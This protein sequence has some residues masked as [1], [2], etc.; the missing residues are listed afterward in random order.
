MRWFLLLLMCCSVIPVGYVYAQTTDSFTVSQV[1]GEDTEPPTV[2]D[3]LQVVPVAAT[4]IDVTWGTS[5]DNFRLSA[6]QLF[7]DGVQIATTTQ[8]SYN[9]IGLTPSTTYA[10]FVR[11]LDWAGN[12]SSSTA[13]VATT[14]FGL[15]SAPDVPGQST[16]VPPQLVSIDID[17]GSENAR[18]TFLARQPLIYE[19]RYGRTSAVEDGFTQSQIFQRRHITYITDLEPRTQYFYELYGTDRFGRKVLIDKGVFTTLDRFV[20]TAVPNAQ[21]FTASVS[22]QNV[23]LSWQ[24]PVMQSFAYV[25]LVRSHYGYPASP[26][27]GIVVYEG[28]GTEFFD[29]AALATHNRQYYTL[30]TFD[31][32]G[33]QSSGAIALA[34]RPGTIVPDPAFDGFEPI[35]TTTPTT[36]T[37]S[38]GVP[39]AA[40]RFLQFSDFEIIQD[41]ILV[42]PVVDLFTVVGETPF[43]LRVPVDRIGRDV[44]TITVIIRYP[45]PSERTTS[46]LLRRN[47]AGTYFEAYLDGMSEE[48]LYSLTIKTFDADLR[49]LSVLRGKLSVVNKVSAGVVPEEDVVYVALSYV[50]IGGVI[51]LLTVLG[52]WWLLLGLLRRVQRRAS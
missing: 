34:V 4:Q 50:I 7:R 41:D 28:T 18:V 30:F 9:D 21:N 49:A 22:G 17:P 27:A 15:P 31:I 45:L 24:N 52:L 37:T 14:T 26:E 38:E 3:P 6:Y 33:R 48:A 51:G 19:L 5:T 12:L 2:P 47:E 25:K 1:Y 44:R 46:Y 13:I 16:L 8:T 32:D 39:D 11:A 29:S 35:E 42:E 43:V 36:T 23:M 40:V 10:Y 20:L